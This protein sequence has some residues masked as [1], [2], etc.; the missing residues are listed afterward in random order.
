MT[1][2]IF[3]TI[4][5][6]FALAAPRCEI[7]N[8]TI[9]EISKLRDMWSGFTPESITSCMSVKPEILKLVGIVFLYENIFLFIYKKISRFCIYYLLSAYFLNSL[10]KLE[11]CI[12]SLL[13]F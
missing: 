3:G 6:V 10:D 12:S 1:V 2:I 7:S 11:N 9:K 5:H 13:S 8:H 4:I